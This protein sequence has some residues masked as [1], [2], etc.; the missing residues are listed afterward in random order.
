MNKRGFT[1]IE[2]LIAITIM[3]IL[4]LLGVVNLSGAQ[5]NGRDSERKTD[6]ETISR[7]L[8]TYYS[9]GS[10]A[11]DDLNIGVYPT[12]TQLSGNESTILRDIDDRALKAPGQSGISLVMAATSS[13]Q[14]PT[15]DEY[16]YQPIQINTDGTYSIC[17]SSNPVCRRYNLYYRLEVAKTS[18]DCP[19][20]G[21][22]CKI[23]SKNQ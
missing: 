12:T 18:S 19:A 3:S 13:D 22:V 23:S 16:I 6:I 17:N 21:Y 2:L 15:I 1:I 9:S 10:G 5:A 7:Y 4:I 8:E 20:P 14:T 11:V